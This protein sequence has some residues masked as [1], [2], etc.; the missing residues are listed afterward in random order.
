MNKIALIRGGFFVGVLVV[1]FSLQWL[2]PSRK[3][4]KDR[5]QFMT[6]NV[7]LVG[8]NNLILGFLPLIP[9]T[10]AEWT[11]NENIGLLN[12]IN[13]PNGI[14]IIM[15]ILLLDLVIYFQHRLFHQV[16]F[17]WRLHSM[18][19]IDPMLDTTSGLRFHPL[20]ILISNF[21]KIGTV[22]VFGISPLGVVIFEV[23]L[24]G[25]S[26]F[27]HS[28]LRLPQKFENILSKVIITPAKHTIHHSK[29]LR[30][31]NSNY[32]FSITWWDRLFG[33]FTEK[34]VYPQEEIRIGIINGP[35]RQ[36]QLFPW[37]LIQPFIK[38]KNSQQENK[39]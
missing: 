32:G 12:Q 8:F 1:F 23:A 28:N 14:A 22:I 4:E 34:G 17:L 13:L 18:H 10:M 36:Y 9:Y 31:T 20:E 26:M 6:S 7:L 29:I 24:N 2:I 3:F 27:N 39:A 11:F 33:T 35:K 5:W 30:E 16:G 19:H 15:G 21:I 37:M 25:F 38:A